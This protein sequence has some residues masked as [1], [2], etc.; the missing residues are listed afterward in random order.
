MHSWLYNH[1]GNLQ[2]RRQLL[3][4]EMGQKQ[5]QFLSF[6][7]T[8]IMLRW[9]KPRATFYSCSTVLRWKFFNTVI[10]ASS[11]WSSHIRICCTITLTL[12]YIPLSLKKK[13]R[14]MKPNQLNLP[15]CKT[16]I[17]TQQH[18]TFPP[19]PP[20]RTP[21]VW[22]HTAVTRHSVSRVLYKPF[23]LPLILSG[24]QTFSSAAPLCFAPPAKASYMACLKVQVF[25]ARHILLC[26]IEP[27]GL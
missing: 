21:E 20:S 25:T 17:I 16:V 27:R 9:V 19:S 3:L 5:C 23:T 1:T 12:N 7:Y 13:T 10:T 6:S 4:E 11:S 2:Q 22:S 18:V 15:H 14:S 24:C 8:A 26:D